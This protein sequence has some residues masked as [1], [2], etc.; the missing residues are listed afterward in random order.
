M[1]F[2]AL[3]QGAETARQASDHT[4]MRTRYFTHPVSQTLEVLKTEFLSTE[5]CP[6]SQHPP[7]DAV[8]L[9]NENQL[10]EQSALLNWL[11][12]NPTSPMTR[13]HVPQTE[14]ESIRAQKDPYFQKLTEQNVPVECLS[15]LW[16]LKG[17][18]VHCINNT[19]EHHIRRV[20]H[21]IVRS[22]RLC[23]I[24][25]RWLSALPCIQSISIYA[26]TQ[27]CRDRLLEFC[28]VQLCRKH[29]SH[30][31]FRHTIAFYTSSN[32]KGGGPPNVCA[33]AGCSIKDGHCDNKCRQIKCADWTALILGGFCDHDSDRLTGLIV[34][35]GQSGCKTAHVIGNMLR[36]SDADRHRVLCRKLCRL[37]D[38]NEG[39]AA[40]FA[41]VYCYLERHCK[42]SNHVSTVVAD[43]MN[44][45]FQKGDETMRS[46]LLTGYDE[47]N[48]WCDGEN[49]PE[50]QNT[51]LECR[52][53]AQSRANCYDTS[54]GLFLYLRY[55]L[56]AN[57]ETHSNPENQL[58]SSEQR[59]RRN[60][61]TSAHGKVFQNWVGR[62][63][64]GEKSAFAK[65][66]SLWLQTAAI[67]G[68]PRARHLSGWYRNDETRM[69]RHTS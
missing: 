33:L 55:V 38:P 43:F 19:R 47:E 12:H 42:A 67:L 24:I 50:G 45:G 39:I 18:A 56:S 23:K 4:R 3:P 49:F 36:C 10:Y 54:Q 65:Q 46:V 8:A 11:D 20:E 69:A 13:R 61:F 34:S 52:V 5:P 17:G 62:R 48:A 53:W 16:L 57:E 14:I 37:A 25:A 6:I 27:L 28:K 35:A 32:R 2:V 63:R 51:A 68:V 66:G 7:V 29:V 22:K 41:F 40:S 31:I 60:F 44:T 30:R 59:I 58:S 9:A 1:L 21:G 15:L 64:E 26:N